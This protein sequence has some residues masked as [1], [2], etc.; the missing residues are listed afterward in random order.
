MRRIPSV[1][2]TTRNITGLLTP[3][4]EPALLLL[5]S[6]RVES[7]CTPFNRSPY[8]LESILDLS[9][10]HSSLLTE[11]NCGPMLYGDQNCCPRGS[12]S[13]QQQESTCPKQS[14]LTLVPPTL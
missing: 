12:K 2:F 4:P 7:L 14:E 3:R 9:A 11:S 13:L 6:T 10:L 5:A 1:S 8:D